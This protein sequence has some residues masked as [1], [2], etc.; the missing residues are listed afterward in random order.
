MFIEGIVL[1]HHISGDGIKVDKSKVELIS[2]LSIPSCQ[3]DVRSFL[4]FIGYYR[5]FIENFTKLASPLFKLLTKDCEFNWNPDCQLA[6]ETLKE[7]ISEAPISRGPNWKTPFHISTYASDTALG[8]VLGQKD[9]IPYAI[10]YTSKNLT[11]TELNCTVTEKEFL[12]V[13]HAINNFRHYITGYETFF[14]TDNSIIRIQNIKDDTPVEDKFPDEYLF[15]V[16]TQTPWFVDIASYLVTRKLPSHFFPKEKR[17]IIQKS[18]SYSWIT[19]ELY[20]TGPYLMI[21][22]CVREYEM[23]EILKACH[24]EPCGGHF[25]DKR[26]AYKIL[27]LGYYWPSIFRDS[28][29]YVKRCDS[30]QRLGNAAPSDEMPL[31][32][33]ILIEPFEKWALD[34]V[35]PINPPS[36]QKKYIL[37]CTD[38]VT[39]WVEANALPFA[40][41]KS[42]VNFIF[43][44]IFTRF[45]V[46]REIVI[47]QGSQFTSKM[48][49]RLVEDYKIKHRKST[50]YNP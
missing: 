39:K 5:K 33:Q 31:Q 34:F 18:A 15:A 32:T 2:K 3:K 25:A 22:R 23:P 17:K 36:K 47:Y 44:D 19:N 41:E 14:H 35:G 37:V 48:V 26:T 20:K 10:Y 50:P 27:H 4:G 49:E 1:G 38:Y 30:C 43:E 40:N 13:V 42:V 46:P 12:A 21:R 16:T 7:N 24:D 45:G 6:F 9:L 28:K 29:E 11:P 8:A